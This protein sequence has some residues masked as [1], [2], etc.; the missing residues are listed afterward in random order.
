MFRQGSEL[1]DGERR[2]V[3]GF[4]AG[5]PVGTAA[6]P[7]TVG[8]CSTDPAR[9]SRAALDAGWNGWGGGVTNTR[10]Q[11]AERGGLR[12]PVVP[13]LELKWAF[14]FPGV[15]SARAQPTVV[16]GRVFVASESGDVFALDA[17]TG[18][19]YWAYHAQAGIRN[20]ISIGPYTSAGGAA[21]YAAYFAD[22]GAVAYA[23][24]AATGREIWRYKVDDHPYTGATGFS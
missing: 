19:T 23:I 13:Q 15:N 3:A 2:A 9:L 8:L 17:K 20:A 24:D 22:Q 10:Y 11:P 14:G 16:G 18:C 1:T 12:G 21:G 4:V 6:S 7:S 5:R